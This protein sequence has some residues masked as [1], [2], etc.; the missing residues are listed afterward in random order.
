MYLCSLVVWGIL[1]L[2]FVVISVVSV[3]EQKWGMFFSCTVPETVAAHKGI[4]LV[5][6]V[7]WARV[8]APEWCLWAFLRLYCGN[9][10]DMDFRA[11]SLSQNKGCGLIHCSRKGENLS[12]D[13]IC[14]SLCPC[15]PYRYLRV[16]F[17]NTLSVIK[18]Y[19]TTSGEWKSKPSASKHDCVVPDSHVW[20]KSE[21][22]LTY[23]ISQNCS[24]MLDVISLL[25][26]LV[27]MKM[28]QA[29]NS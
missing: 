12:L 1:S 22:L 10:W 18:Q 9:F 19:L 26:L 14:Y 13:L 11:L 27:Q 15:S 16:A 28:W 20:P 8:G 23:C 29:S 4:A 25:L 17:S 21:D 5:C 6:F 2:S 24:N 3:S 7:F